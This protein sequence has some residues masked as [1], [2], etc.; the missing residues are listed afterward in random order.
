M[1]ALADQS[2]AAPR[3]AA[4]QQPAAPRPGA[5]SPPAKPL[6]LVGGYLGSGKT[7]LINRFLASPEAGRT[8]VVVNDFGDVNIDA[9]RIRAAGA[10]TLELTN[11]CICCQITDN[12]QT[13]MAGLAQREDIDRVICEVS[14]IGDPSQLGTWRT[15]PGFRPGPVVVCADAGATRARLTNEYIEDVV[16][17]QI[18]RADVVLVTKAGVTDPDLV[19]RTRAAC[20]EIAPQAEVLVTADDPTDLLAVLHRWEAA[21]RAAP[22]V[23]DGPIHRRGAGHADLHRTLTVPLERTATAEAVAAV[24]TEAADLLVRAKGFI[25]DARGRWA[26]VQLASGAVTVD[27]LPDYG[28][29]RADLVLIAAGPQAA[30]NLTRVAAALRGTG[31]SD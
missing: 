16:R 31:P 20:A 11:G 18:A 26:E 10:D 2:P 13:L 7:T 1:P 27:A 5:T 30:E 6:T 3:S 24:L 19:E 21:D 25:P 14:G 4:D 28:P 22:Q 12:V 29:A 8:A 23:P 17:A 9:E 15:F